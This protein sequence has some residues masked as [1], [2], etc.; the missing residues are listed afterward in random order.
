M[1][2]FVRLS[3]VVAVV[4]TITLVAMLMVTGVG[5]TRSAGDGHSLDAADGN[6][7]DVVYVD[8][9]GNVGVGTTTPTEM[10]EVSGAIKI[11]DTT[12]PSAGTIR[13]VDPTVTPGTTPP[14]FA[15]YD[16]SRWLSL[17][18]DYDWY[19]SGGDIYSAVSGNVGIGTS[20]PE[21]KLDVNGEAR[22]VIGAQEYYMVPK[23]G[24]IM[25]SDP[26]SIPTGWAICNGA[27]GTPDLR[28]RFIVSVGDRYSLGETGGYEETWFSG[29]DVSVC[30]WR[31]AT[32][33]LETISVWQD[34][35]LAAQR[36]AIDGGAVYTDNRPPFYALIFIMRVS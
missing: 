32:N 28:D 24:I 14:Y 29:N 16:G 33:V 31:Q 1:R 35:P 21:E 27:N 6:P 22:C 9:T 12:N 4:G 25:W 10:L 8:D 13:Y 26:S 5:C 11:G 19:S 3:W 17:V 7:T 34:K 20:A 23:G 36:G 30:N 15:G 2:N 18:S